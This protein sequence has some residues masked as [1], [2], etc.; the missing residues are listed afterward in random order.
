MHSNQVLSGGSPAV[1]NSWL[2]NAGLKHHA[3]NFQGVEPEVFRSLLM[4]DYAKYGVTSLEDKQKLF[5]LVKSL[6]MPSSLDVQQLPKTSSEQASVADGAGAPRAS[7]RGNV[8]LLDLEAEVEKNRRKHQA[9]ERV[10]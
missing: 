8:G 4:Q 1:V 10:E 9:Y 5:R 3:G 2:A 6:Q 7:E